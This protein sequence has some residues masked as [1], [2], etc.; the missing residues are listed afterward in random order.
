MRVTSNSDYVKRIIVHKEPSRKNLLNLC[1]AF[2][3][4]A[5]IM[6]YIHYIHSY[7]HMNILKNMHLHNVS[8]TTTYYAIHGKEDI[9]LNARQ[10]LMRTY[11]AEDK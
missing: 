10:Q 7:I 9:I 4:C 6:P 1:D 3:Y 8:L 11:F 5:N 2:F